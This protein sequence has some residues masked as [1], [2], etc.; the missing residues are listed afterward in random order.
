MKVISSTDNKYLGTEI[1]ETVSLGEVISLGD[2]GFEISKI[3]HQ[4]SGQMILENPNYQLVLEQ[5]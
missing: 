2:Y 1:P 4:E 5:E 3:V